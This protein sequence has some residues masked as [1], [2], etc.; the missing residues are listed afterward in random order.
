MGLADDFPGQ[1]ASDQRQMRPTCAE[2]RRRAA[3]LLSGSVGPGRGAHTPATRSRPPNRQA[4][5]GVVRWCPCECR[6]RVSRRQ[7]LP[8]SALLDDR[9]SIAQ[10]P[11]VPRGYRCRPS[12]SRV[13]RRP[14]LQLP[15]GI[16]MFYR[17]QPRDA[18]ALMGGERPLIHHSVV[19]LDG[20]RRRWLRADFATVRTR[21]SASLRSGDCIQCHRRSRT[22]AHRRRRHDLAS[23]SPDAPAGE[24]ASCHR[25]GTPGKP[26]RVIRA[27]HKTR[28]HYERRTACRSWSSTGY[29]LVA[30]GRLF[31]VV[32]ISLGNRSIS[33]NSFEHSFR[34]AAGHRHLGQDVRPNDPE[35][36]QT[37]S[38][39]IFR[40]LDNRD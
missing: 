26:E 31:R 28:H 18:S 6:G 17:Y 12:R 36:D 4:S 34:R 5:P 33:A 7:P 9:T 27:D 25:A 20:T 1:I 11:T 15:V 22:I 38:T 8:R 32:G 21:R 23:R 29:R 35:P 13:S 39:G 24:I 16:R 37:V 40:T 10:G 2:H 19:T 3:N 14:P 30:P